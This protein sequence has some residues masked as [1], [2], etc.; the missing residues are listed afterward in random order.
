MT[1]TP[2][3]WLSSDLVPLDLALDEDLQARHPRLVKDLWQEQTSY[4][5]Q[6]KLAYAQV[7]TDLLTA[8][9]YINAQIPNSAANRAQVKEGVVRKAFCVIFLDFISQKDDR[10]DVLRNF[11]LGEYSAWLE[12]VAL[13]YDEDDDGTISE[14]EEAV[15]A[16]LRLV[17]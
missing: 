1:I 2:L 15:Q 9:E 8:K 6:L 3:A 10:W 13:E 17:R 5:L 4:D 16:P 7:V 11:Y 14:G 12:Q